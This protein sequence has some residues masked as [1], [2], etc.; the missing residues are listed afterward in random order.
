MTTKAAAAPAQT[1]GAPPITALPAELTDAVAAVN[2]AAQQCDKL[3]LAI[4]QCPVERARLDR[5][6]AEL[7]EKLAAAETSLALADHGSNA[8]VQHLASVE[9]LTLALAA[10]ER[11]RRRVY[12]PQ[13]SLAPEG[14]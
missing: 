8:E 2:K 13:A 10:I 3:D 5:E 11:E 6:H 12:L 14:P 1:R 7:S 9:K 4:D